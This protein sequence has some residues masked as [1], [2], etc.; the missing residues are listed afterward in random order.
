MPYDVGRR[1]GDVG[2]R[3]DSQPTKP[4]IPGL[5]RGGGGRGGPLGRRG[6]PRTTG[7]H[8]RGATGRSV[9][10][11]G[12][13]GT[14]AMGAGDWLCRPAGSSGDGSGRTLHDGNRWADATP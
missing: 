11:V 14:Q 12:G 1:T 4:T 7:S 5:G 9:M 8:A 2:R 10:P 3:R 13:Q 6:I